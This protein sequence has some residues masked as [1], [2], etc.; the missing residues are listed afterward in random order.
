[1]PLGQPA[2]GYGMSMMGCN[3]WSAVCG[4]QWKAPQGS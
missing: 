4:T 2:N 3:P 1:M